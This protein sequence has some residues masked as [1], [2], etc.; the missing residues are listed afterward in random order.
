MKRLGLAV[1][2]SLLF[3]LRGF[4]TDA[5]TSAAAFLDIGF[6]SRAQG[7]SNGVVA[8][9]DDATAS[10]FNP[11]GLTAASRE[12][13]L[14]HSVWFQDIALSQAAL[15][16]PRDGY[17]LGFSVTR[18][19]I[20]GIEA[21][22]AETPQP[23]GT[24]GAQ[25]LSVAVSG[26]RRF[27]AGS[28]GL[29]AKWVEQAIASTSGSSGALDVGVRYPL[30]DSVM[31]GLAVRNIGPSLH[32]GS[33]AFPLPLSFHAGVS[34]SAPLTLVLESSYSRDGRSQVIAGSEYWLND[35]FAMRGGYL[36]QLAA[37]AAA[38]PTNSGLLP[39]P[40]VSAGFGLRVGRKLE[41]DYA[42]VPFRDLGS[43]HRVSLSIKF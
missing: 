30:T 10:Y 13:N 24:F 21:R 32:F 19:G 9:A 36:D 4:C 8:F 29:T 16:L 28:I 34:Y 31:G 20:E 37:G 23:T 26:A 35:S 42:I 6:G 25:D 22:T 18:L 38:N 5:G 39:F 33:E 11:A 3:P 40:G 2:F 14:S 17:S 1:V 15:A 27:G 41:L 7:L 43:A 12:F